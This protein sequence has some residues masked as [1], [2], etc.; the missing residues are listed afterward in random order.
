MKSRMEKQDLRVRYGDRLL[1]VTFAVERVELLFRNRRDL[2]REY[3]VRH[4]ECWVS[5]G[6]LCD[7]QP[8]FT[9]D[10]DAQDNLI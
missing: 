2:L 4:I 6:D 10:L 7:L 1:L 8:G 3:G 9:A 5:S